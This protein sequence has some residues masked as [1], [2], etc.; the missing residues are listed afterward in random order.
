M[1]GSQGVIRQ[2]SEQYKIYITTAAMEHPSSLFTAAH[3]LNET[4]YVR[5][6]NWQ[7]VRQYFL[8]K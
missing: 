5:V 1:Q 7:D 6:H 3:N 8:L 2:L 4:G